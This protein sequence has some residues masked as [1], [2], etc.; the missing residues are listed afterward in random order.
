MTTNLKT[1]YNIEYSTIDAAASGE[2]YAVQ[3]KHFH[4]DSFNM[5]YDQTS[6]ALGDN[7]SGMSKIILGTS[8]YGTYWANLTYGAWA[9]QVCGL[10]TM[11]FLFTAVAFNVTVSKSMTAATVMVLPDGANVRIVFLNGRQ[12]ITPIES[13]ELV[14]V[15]PHSLDLQIGG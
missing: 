2:S 7:S 10:G 4:D 6:F 13:I 15:K 14:K 1:N 9:W 3:R 8:V 11:T 12:T 5:I